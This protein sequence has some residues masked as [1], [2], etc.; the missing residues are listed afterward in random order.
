VKGFLLGLVAFV[1]AVAAT[2]AAALP[3]TFSIGQIF[4]NADGTVQFVVIH[5]RGMNDCDAG[6][7]R[8]AGLA[9]I[10]TGP[11]PQ[12][13]YV[14]PANLPT[15]KTSGR[16]MLIATEGFAALG[17]VSPDYVI[18]NGFLQMPS[19]AVD[20]AGVSYLAYAALPNDGVTALKFDGMPTQNVAT[21]L[22]GAS[23]SVV[24]GLTPAIATVVEFYNL[25]LDH[26][27]ITWVAQEI[28][29]LDNGVH[30]GWART[31]YSF[32]AHLKAQAGTSPVCRFYI[33]PALGD[34]HF[35]GR[36]TAECVATGQ[37]NPSV[38]NEDLAF[39][40]MFL[41]AAGVC[42]AGTAEI[43]RVF[44]NRADA[45]HRYMTDKAVRQTMVDRGWLAEGDGPNVVV[46]CAPG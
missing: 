41:P 35:F 7:N 18:P 46:M 39:M 42:P 6:E 26:Y 25:G 1:L 33:P 31:G 21:N 34:S 37:K 44:S 14:F 19:G 45:N 43:Y 9:L 5:D 27:F 40:E 10:S 28:S 36:G 12:R 30:K 32:R 24:P 11:G 8:W 16:D 2:T 22:A 38:V 15:C 3:E 20:F 17:I 23:A 29:D 4:S 13:S